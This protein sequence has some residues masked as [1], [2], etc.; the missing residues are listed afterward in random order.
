MEFSRKIHKHII[1]EA[2]VLTNSYVA[3]NI[4]GDASEYNTLSLEV[5]FTL[6]SLT[7]MEMKVEVSNDG[8]N[9]YQQ[10]AESTSGGS[11][12]VSLDERTWDATGKYAFLIRPVRAKYIRVSVKGTGTVTDS[13][14]AIKGYLAWS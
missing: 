1:R 11:T 4:I 10:V 12:T 9:W 5:D 3:G 7:S 2:A 6:G 8:T 14:C 13:S